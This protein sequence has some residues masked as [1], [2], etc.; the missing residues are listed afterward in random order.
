MPGIDG[1]REERKFVSVESNQSEWMTASDRMCAK[2]EEC[3]MNAFM[4]SDPL[5]PIRGT[6]EPVLWEH[7]T[8]PGLLLWHLLIKLTFNMQLLVRKHE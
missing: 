7:Q 6:S 1:A 3:R 4:F 2:C 8:P 5:V